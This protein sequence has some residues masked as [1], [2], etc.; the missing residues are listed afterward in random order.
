M[1]KIFFTL[2]LAIA[3]C[4]VSAQN[5][6]TFPGSGNV[7]I[8]TTLPTAGL[9]IANISNGGYNFRVTG[10]YTN[11]NSTTTRYTYGT[12]GHLWDVTYGDFTTF[13]YYNGST[14]S[15]NRLV[16][17]NAGNL[18]IAGNLNVNGTGLSTIAGS[19]GI[20][21]T[22]VPVGYTLAVNGSAIATSITVQSY[23]S[24]PDYVFKSDYQLPLLTTIKTY[25]DQNHHLPEIPSADRIAKD[26][27][28]LGEMDKLLTK[29]VEELTLYLIE[30]DKQLNYINQ[31]INK[32]QIEIEVQQ[33]TSR[34][35]QEQSND[36]LKA[37]QEQID[38]LKKQLESLIKSKQ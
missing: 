14:W 18:G 8:G 15:T 35:A 29:K 10:G 1:K 37:Q 34:L 19:F 32:Q 11:F 16:F 9:D 3:C 38:Q 21:T 17:N 20:N 25:I 23:G 33:N 26:G 6:N 4:A 7:G 24:W 13:N 27:L 5:T 12:S 2:S 22:N 31:I 28:N 30:K 36:L